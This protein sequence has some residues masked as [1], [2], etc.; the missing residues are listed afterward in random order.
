MPELLAGRGGKSGKKNNKKK[1][2]RTREEVMVDFD[3]ALDQIGPF[4]KVAKEKVPKNMSKLT[5]D[6]KLARLVEAAPEALDLCTEVKVR[7]QELE[8]L[9]KPVLIAHTSGKFE[10]HTTAL[11]YVQLRHRMLLVYLL[12]LGY[13]LYLRS[14]KTP[15]SIVSPHPNIRQIVRLRA[16]LAEL[17]EIHEQIEPLLQKYLIVAN[18]D[19][20]EHDN[21]DS[22]AADDV[23]PES[24]DAQVAA[25]DSIASQQQHSHH[26]VTEMD[27]LSVTPVKIQR[28]TLAD[29]RSQKE[30]LGKSAKRKARKRRIAATEIGDGAA[31]DDTLADEVLLQRKQS[32]ERNPFGTSVAKEE[33]WS[34]GA[35][36]GD[37][38]DDAA[39]ALYDAVKASAEAKK[40]K[41]VYTVEQ[42]ELEGVTDDNRAITYAMQ[43]NRGL[44]PSRRKEMRNPRVRHRNKFTKAT[45]R[46]KGQVIEMRSQESK[47]TGEAFGI[48]TDITKST[49]LK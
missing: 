26:R 11:E 27:S 7:S 40:S 12:N 23:H 49:K 2:S 30:S 35:L 9:I 33:D 32:Q 46:R 10:L 8:E 38:S 15:T 37:E 36:D 45:K 47:Y 48:R 29:A 6:E 28:M 42:P 25:A 22:S 3:A 44:T 39:A 17:D 18:H 34:L 14:L 20:D 13:Y 19:S 31:G 41:S 4:G 16:Q 1:D 43:K 24:D 5:T 21:S